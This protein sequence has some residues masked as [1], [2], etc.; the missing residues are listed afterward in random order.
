[1]ELYKFSFGKVYVLQHDLGEVIVNNEADINVLMVD[2]LHELLLSIFNGSFSL[3]INKSHSYS[4]Q[5]DALVKFGKLPE[6]NKIAVYAPN[7]LAKLS[8]D[9]AA[10]IPSSSELDIEVFT[11]RE[12]AMSWL[13]D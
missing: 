1:M 11:D 5:L 6:I 7:D 4:T 13:Q 3:F 8:A 9:F 10:D 2:E 12:E